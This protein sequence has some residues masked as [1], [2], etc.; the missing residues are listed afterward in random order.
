[1]A[2]VVWLVNSGMPQLVDWIKGVEAPPES[3]RLFIVDT[4]S[5]M[6]GSL[7]KRKRFATVRREIEKI[8]QGEPDDI[9]YAVRTTTGYGC[10]SDWHE[11]LVEFESGDSESVPAKLETVRLGGPGDIV[12]AIRQGKNDF[13]RYG[14]AESAESKT[15]WLFL[16]TTKNDCDAAGLP[17]GTAIKEALVDASASLKS[18]DFFVL[19]RPGKRVQAFKRAIEGLG[20]NFVVRPVSTPKQL[21]KA[22]VETARRETVSQH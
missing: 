3:A 14:D 18:V 15:I 9:A 12:T 10:D 21:R 6:T 20:G 4:S 13:R 16:A 1:V 7:G 17:L 2:V 19:R 8:T 11:P 22:L 5:S